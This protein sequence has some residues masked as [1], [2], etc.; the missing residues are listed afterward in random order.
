MQVMIIYSPTHTQVQ[1]PYNK[2]MAAIPCYRKGRGIIGERKSERIGEQTARK[3]TPKRSQ[4]LRQSHLSL[5]PSSTSRTLMVVDSMPSR[6]HQQPTSEG[7]VQLYWHLHV[8]AF[9]AKRRRH[10]TL[11]ND[12]VGAFKTKTEIS[13]IG[14][15]AIEKKKPLGKQVVTIH[16]QSKT[17]TKEMTTS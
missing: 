15:A 5:P 13:G 4:S 3:S 6:G 9:E 8:R 1:K 17:D 12:L 11:S 2:K 10:A 7:S 16:R 14:P